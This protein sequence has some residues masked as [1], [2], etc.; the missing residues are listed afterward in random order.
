[1]EKEIGRIMSLEGAARARELYL[2]LLGMRLPGERTSLTVDKNHVLILK[3]LAEMAGVSMPEVIAFLIWTAA[4]KTA[5]EHA[6][7][8]GQIQDAVEDMAEA[9]EGIEAQ[10][11]AATDAVLINAYGN[12]SALP[13]VS[14]EG[15]VE[16][17]GRLKGMP[18]DGVNPTK[19][20]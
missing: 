10:L 6:G 20:A 7:I 9:M 1:M 16:L 18:A 8:V 14:A 17:E 11:D 3:C 15:E 5:F 19:E 13:S 12:L 4:E 2:F